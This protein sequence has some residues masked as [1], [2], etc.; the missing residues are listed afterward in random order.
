MAYPR[1]LRLDDSTR[2][3]QHE[4]LGITCLIGLAAASAVREGLSE[5]S[6]PVTITIPSR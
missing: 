2:D 1:A 3:G 4:I 5:L 6:A